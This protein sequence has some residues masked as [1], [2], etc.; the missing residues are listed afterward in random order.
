MMLQCLWALGIQAL[1]LLALWHCGPD[2][3]SRISSGLSG[4]KYN[5]GKRHKE[6]AACRA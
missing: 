6:W 3:T 1:I 2:V 5:S 4:K